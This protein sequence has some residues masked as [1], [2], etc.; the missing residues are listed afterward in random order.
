MYKNLEKVIHENHMTINSAALA[1]GMNE[2]S[3]RYKIDRETFDVAEAFKIHKILFPRY[4][5]YY[6]FTSDNI[7]NHT[8]AAEFA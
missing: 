6:L 4:D 2:R 7:E 1:I 3:L 8:E 5:F